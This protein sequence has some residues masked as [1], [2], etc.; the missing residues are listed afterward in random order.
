MGINTIAV[1]FIIATVVSGVY[2]D[3]SACTPY[4]SLI[5]ISA[6][7]NPSTYLTPGGTAII[8]NLTCI[9]NDFMV[10]S[11]VYED[12]LFKTNDITGVAASC[13]IVYSKTG[14]A[15][16]AASSYNQG[17][18]C[19]AYPAKNPQWTIVYDG[20]GSIYPPN[21]CNG[22]QLVVINKCTF[23]ITIYSV[24]FGAET[25]CCGYSI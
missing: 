14:E 19:N 5:K 4:R 11:Q 18:T 25:A 15:V 3:S 12:Y 8:G 20:N 16:G 1:C 17:S 24:T 21:A 22:A 6:T 23:S 13:L 2:A 9:A 10:S 7:S